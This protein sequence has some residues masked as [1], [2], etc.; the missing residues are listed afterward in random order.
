[1]L[2]YM[3]LHVPLRMLLLMRSQDVNLMVLDP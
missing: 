1:M 3:L 2:L